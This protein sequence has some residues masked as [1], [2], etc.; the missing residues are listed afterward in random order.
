MRG[1][2][3]PA[4]RTVILLA[5]ALGTG[6]AWANGLVP[7]TGPL[8]EAPAAPWTFA[9]LPA[10]K[11]P[12]TRFTLEREG[13]GTVLRVET[14]ASYGNLVHPLDGAP[15]GRLAWRWRVERPLAAAD[16]RR[17]DGDDVALKVCALFAMPMAAVPF[18]ERQLLRLAEA[19]SGTALPTAT[20]CYVWAPEWP[21]G[22][23][24][25]N[26]YSRRVRYLTLGSRTAGWQAVQRDLA[27]DFLRA[28]GDEASSV[29]P[30]QAVGVGADADNTGGS[31]LAFLADL[32][33]L[34]PAAR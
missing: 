9:G 34:P 25:P 6:A 7:W 15:A 8:G 10:Q 13:A 17:R 5:A 26:A 28:F 32:I 11:P 20:L 22:Q 2:R 4:R 1:R 16:L 19:R 14:A 31:S 33:L 27:A 30:L 21:E 24:L 23:V 29:P 12:P 18:V 3:R